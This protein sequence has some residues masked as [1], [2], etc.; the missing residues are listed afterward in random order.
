MA[1]ITPDL[2]HDFDFYGYYR[3]KRFSA[4]DVIDIGQSALYKLDVEALHGTLFQFRIIGESA[5]FDIHLFSA[6]PLEPPDL[7]VLENILSVTDIDKHYDDS[8]INTAWTNGDDPRT[9]FLY[10]YVTNNGAV[11]MTPVW[12]VFYRKFTIA[13]IVVDA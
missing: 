4:P 3:I 6:L 8:S 5:D 10:L 2:V 12:E 1:A 7:D 9:N 11:E 13:P